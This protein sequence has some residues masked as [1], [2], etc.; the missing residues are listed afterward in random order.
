M[1]AISKKLDQWL[2]AGLLTPA[3]Y[4]AISSYE[5]A[6]PQRTNTWLYSFMVLGALIIGL[7]V[8]SLI[9]AN[10]AYI[11]ETV[12]LS[13]AFALLM[14]LASGIY[15]QY[16]N[17]KTGLW[18]EIFLVSFLIMC[19]A[20]IGLI[21]QIY[22]LGEQW[23]HALVL[24]ATITSIIVLFA[25]NLLTRFLWV[26]LALHGLIWTLVNL[27]SYS[28]NHWYGEFP[29]LLLFSPLFSIALYFICTQVSVLRTFRSSLFF[30]FQ[31]SAIIAL[32]FID[33][34]RSGGELN[35][36]QVYR[37]LPA[38]IA[39]LMVAIGIVFNKDYRLLNK[40]LLLTALGLL[41][42]YYY[43]DGL[44]TGQ[45]RYTL[46]GSNHNADIS[47]WQADDIRAPFLTLLIL[48]LYAIHA[49][50]VG[51]QR[52]FNLLT[53]LIGLRFIILYF[54]AMGGLA[55]TGIGLIIS[56]SLIIGLAWLWYK[57]RDK[58]R[59]WTE[60]LEA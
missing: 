13:V 26:T 50:N 29:T 34:T 57:Q 7:G 33:I 10:W 5:L 60:E 19:L 25:R 46:F 2:Q 17:R 30:W 44:F 42:L 23:Y 12:K 31:I 36:Y 52:L 47:F 56:G 55:A 28:N 41:L 37:Y 38:Y 18:F 58:L 15:W 9:A 21:A 51:Q 27:N 43:P 4:E 39:A 24:W 20:T 35:D 8:I 40:F 32:I 6:H 3:Q 59:A 1:S 16:P 14:I 22:H 53:F 48:F 54:Q 45:Q 49:G 11:P